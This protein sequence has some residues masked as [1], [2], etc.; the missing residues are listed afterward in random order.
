MIKRI[1]FA[2]LMLSAGG[3]VSCDGAEEQDNLAKAQKCL[4]E[5]PQSDPTAANACLEFVEKYTSQQAS[6]LKCAIYTVSG[7][8]MENR[9]LKGYQVLS[10]STITHKEAAFMAVLSLD[11]P[12]LTAGLAKAK[13]A[14]GFCLASG[15]PGL[16]YLSNIIVAGTAMNKTISEMAGGTAIGSNSSSTDIKNAVNAMLSSCTGGSPDAACDDNLVDLGTA[17]AT[18]SVS[19]CANE[20]ADDDVCEKVNAATAAAGNNATNIGQA[21]LCYMNNKSFN[22]VTPTTCGP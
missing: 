7:G 3:L 10:D 13:L 16:M 22:P 18:L 4:D 19:Y 17:V 20:N 15:V 21:L 5:V 6:I 14:N 1:L 9:V 8:L 12:N 11:T 2:A